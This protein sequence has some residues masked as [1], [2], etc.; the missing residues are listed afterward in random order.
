MKKIYC[1]SGLGADEKAFAKI[2]VAGYELEFI[3]WLTPEKNERI[4]AYAMRMSQS[5]K[6]ENP[7][8]MGLSFGGIMCIEMAKLM[9]VAKLI[10]ISSVPAYK[11]IPLWMRTAGK[12]KLNKV[13]P[14][15][16]ASTLLEPVQNYHIGAGT[17]EEKEIVRQYRKMV[18]PVYL[19]WAINAIL[20]WKNVWR[21]KSVYH[22]HGDADRIFPIKNVKPDYIVKG[23]THFM[24]YTKAKEISEKLSLLLKD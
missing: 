14:M 4:E 11:Q 10:L 17:D 20:N 23:G 12:L 13:L 22:L 16:S 18:S 1:V 19:H 5:V 7:V 6:E 21:P 3:Q 8:L 9:P 2:K 15:R 24:V